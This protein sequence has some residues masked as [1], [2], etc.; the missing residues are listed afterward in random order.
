MSNA[1]AEVEVTASSRSL[2]ARL[3]EAR[4]KFSA[5]GSE[6]KKNVFGKDL[7]EKGFMSKAGA[8]MVGNLG[9]S[10]LSAFGGMIADQ[11]KE[12]FAFNDALTRL[13]ITGGKT[14]EFMQAFATSIRATSS[15]VGVSATDI[16]GASQKYV[17]LTGDMDGASKSADQWARVAQ[18]TGSTVGDIA[19]TAAALKQ[20]MHIS[21][22]EMEATFSALAV[23]GKK[24]A[25]ELKDLSAQMSTIA[26]QWAMFKGGTGVD[27][28]R[29]LGAAL[30]VV[31]RGFGGDAAETITGLQSLLNA[32][33]KNAGRLKSAKVNVYESDG[34][35][36]K[37]LRNILDIVKDI[38]NSPLAKDP[39]KLAKALGRTEAYRAYLQLAQNKDVLD[40]LITASSDAGVIQRDLAT[41]SES[42]GGRTK[43][44][45]QQAKNE[46]AAAFTP[47]RIEA[48][49]SLLIKATKALAAIASG[50]SKVIDGVASMGEY[51][52]RS[53]SLVGGNE[54]VRKV[55]NN[56][57]P[58]A[59]DALHGIFVSPEQDAAKVGIER[60]QAEA[61]AQRSR[62]RATVVSDRIQH[63]KNPNDG[64]A[65]DATT[66]ALITAEN[67]QSGVVNATKTAAASIPDQN[68]V[69]AVNELGRLMVATWNGQ[70]KPPIDV[71]VGADA[72][73]RANRNGGNAHTTRPGG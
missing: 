59:G 37:Q 4:S 64:A 40:E 71:K 9:S 69:R 23:Q 7:V 58:G 14:P 47:E 48:F 73:V 53:A 8:Q 31:K 43:I 5:F 72:V 19:E 27:G 17:A 63:G 52:G 12:V 1:K 36:G 44:A 10:A 32:T 60:A 66:E 50:I 26:P 3:R 51:A 34:K 46:I 20:N 70:T 15:A 62:I 22:G 16:L 55:L 6:L 13:Q 25:I 54:T 11:G 39:T 2:G 41:Y 65:V 24:G 18:A 42:A 21:P 61:D 33:I 57:A 56:F 45:W 68:I 30:Q 49:T 67:V 29:Q 28:V 35:G 38:G